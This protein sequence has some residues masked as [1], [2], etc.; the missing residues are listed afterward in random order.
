V[1]APISR[2]PESG[3]VE[4][5]EVFDYS[6]NGLQ[7]GR[8]QHPSRQC[9]RTYHSSPPRGKALTTD[10]PFV[11]TKEVP[12]GFILVEAIDMNEAL[13]IAA[14]IPLAGSIEVLP[15]MQ[16]NRSPHRGVK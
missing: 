5:V 15:V 3:W 11:E 9:R 12:G 7:P 1:G 16:M 8:T 14:G 10:G 2:A 13:E 6:Y 4:P